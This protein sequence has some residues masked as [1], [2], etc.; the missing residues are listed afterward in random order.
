MRISIGVTAGLVANFLA[1]G[2]AQAGPC[3]ADIAQFETA[4]RQSGG[5]PDAGLMARQSV[6]AQLGHQPTPGSVSHAEDRLQSKFSA[7]MARA[8]QLDA[9]GN[10]AGCTSALKAAKR[11][12]IP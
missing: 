10:R 1:C 8:K 9:Q 12:Y 11:I 4:V 3:T 7:K 2:F 6:G 5:N